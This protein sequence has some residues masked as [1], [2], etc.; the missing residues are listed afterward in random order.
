MAISKVKAFE[1]LLQKIRTCICTCVK[2]VVSVLIQLIVNNILRILLRKD[3][4]HFQI[5]LKLYFE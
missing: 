4:R 1:Y 3:V 2:H 5:W